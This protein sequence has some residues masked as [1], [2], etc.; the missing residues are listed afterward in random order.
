MAKQIPFPARHVKKMAAWLL[1]CSASRESLSRPGTWA[2]RPAPPEPLGNML[3]RLVLIRPHV[4][5]V[6]ESVVAEAL[7]TIEREQR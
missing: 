4:V 2:N 7:A 5:L 3:Q 6:L 1:L